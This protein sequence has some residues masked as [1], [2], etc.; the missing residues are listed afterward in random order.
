M[1]SN[2]HLPRVS[3]HRTIEALL[4]LNKKIP[5]YFPGSVILLKPSV[6]G[7]R[8]VRVRAK[9]ALVLFLA[10][11]VVGNFAALYFGLLLSSSMVA[12]HG[13]GQLRFWVG[14]LWVEVRTCSAHFLG[15]KTRDLLQ[16][17]ARS[18]EEVNSDTT[19]WSVKFD[20]SVN[21]VFPLG[22]GL[23]P[24]SPKL[25]NGSQLW[26]AVSRKRK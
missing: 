5:V 7:Y 11:I 12:R 1:K 16:K 15:I 22:P 4:Q 26:G 6:I 19:R 9:L 24:S 25:W 2:M 23:K 3:G 8:L 21:Y 17:K 10:R 13:Q 14:G 20:P 18:C